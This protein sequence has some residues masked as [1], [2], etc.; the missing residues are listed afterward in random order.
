MLKLISLREHRERRA[1]TQRELATLAAMTQAT[2]VRLEGGHDARPTTVR[3]LA[4]ALG[5]S[6]A[7][8]LT[9]IAGRTRAGW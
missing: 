5:V 7:E 3:K 1:L 4:E 2:I 8:L 9:P 6:P